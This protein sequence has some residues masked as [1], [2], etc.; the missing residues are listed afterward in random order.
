MPFLFILVLAPAVV[1]MLTPA[2]EGAAREGIR[3]FMN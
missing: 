1:A 2:E 3:N